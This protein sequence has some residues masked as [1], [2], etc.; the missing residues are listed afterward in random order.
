[1]TQVNYSIHPPLS[2]K[3]VLPYIQPRKILMKLEAMTPCM[4][5]MR[6]IEEIVKRQPIKTMDKF[7]NLNQITTIDAKVPKKLASDAADAAHMKEN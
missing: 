1:M 4:I 2:E 7:E 3:E 6:Q 5:I